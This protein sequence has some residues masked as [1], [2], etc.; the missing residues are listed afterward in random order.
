MKTRAKGFTLIEI[1]V[2]I[3]IMGSLVA[4]GGG[5]SAGFLDYYKVR[6]GAE[7]LVWQLRR[8]RTL[9]M[10][11]GA[12]TGNAGIY[13]FAQ[14]VRADKTA[15]E[16]PGFSYLVW[17]QPYGRPRPADGTTLATL[18]AA[19]LPF[20]ENFPRGV[21]L[22]SDAVD[23]TRDGNPINLTEINATTNLVIFEFNRFGV[24]QAPVSRASQAN[25]SVDFII[26]GQNRVFRVVCW[27]APGS[28]TYP[29]MQI[30]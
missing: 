27:G 25:G 9:I 14:R 11:R 6:G 4:V 17:S 13:L 8:A 23:A 10:S 29:T 16:G 1:M 18:P 30:F 21:R 12:I 5:L 15:P 22:V 2:V 20:V 7:T 26:D 19:S 3:T 24:R 28:Q